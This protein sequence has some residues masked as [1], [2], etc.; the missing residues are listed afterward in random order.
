MV[1]VFVNDCSLTKLAQREFSPE[2][3]KFLRPWLFIQQHLKLALY[4]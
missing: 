3:L 1:L 2:A 4:Q